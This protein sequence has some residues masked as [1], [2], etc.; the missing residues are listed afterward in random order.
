MANSCDCVD[1]L[2]LLIKYCSGTQDTIPDMSRLPRA[3]PSGRAFRQV[4]AADDDVDDDDDVEVDDDDGD[5]YSNVQEPTPRSTTPFRWGVAESEVGSQVSTGAATEVLS[6]TR[7]LGFVGRLRAAVFGR[8]AQ[9][10]IAFGQSGR[11]DGSDVGSVYS[12]SVGSVHSVQSA[13]AVPEPM[14]CV[15][16]G[17][18]KL[19]AGKNAV[20]AAA[21]AQQLAAVAGESCRSN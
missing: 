3:R 18:I 7:D 6:S 4:A 10:A 1:S 16:R 5:G 12:S 2:V 21:T 13:F 8:K 17:E 20:A 15:S 9:R 11:D 14:A 19:P